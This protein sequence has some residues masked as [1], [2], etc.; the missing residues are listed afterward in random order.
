MFLPLYFLSFFEFSLFWGILFKFLT[1]P[2]PIK[3]LSLFYFLPFF[4]CFLDS[5]LIKS[6][7]SS[8][9]SFPLSSTCPLNSLFRFCPFSTFSAPSSSAES[10]SSSLPFFLDSYGFMSLY[11]SEL[12]SILNSWSLNIFPNLPSS[13]IL[14]IFAPPFLLASFWFISS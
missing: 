7:S 10:T 9:S 14:S 3:I 5:L 11:A 1:D 13:I 4:Y 12:L 6:P 8:S 2:F